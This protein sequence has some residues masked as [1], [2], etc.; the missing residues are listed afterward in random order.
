MSIKRTVKVKDQL[1][2]HWQKHADES[3]GKI[4]N[5]NVHRVG[6]LGTLFGT[7]ALGATVIGYFP[8][9]EL[10]QYVGA[11]LITANTG[12]AVTANYYFNK[13][14]TFY[15]KIKDYA[16][17][18]RN[19]IFQN[20]DLSTKTF[21]DVQLAD[22][23]E[24][25]NPDLSKPSDKR[26]YHINQAGIANI[27]AAGLLAWHLNS[28]DDGNVPTVRKIEGI[29]ALVVEKNRLETNGGVVLV[30]KAQ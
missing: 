22:L 27:F 14:K 16:E 13:D 8:S 10:T 3:H 12:L 1:I 2:A 15:K 18:K 21:T 20:I 19:D 26:L 11:L 23:I 7:T 9:N 30:P 17:T 28:S 5:A 25:E 29:S 24:S 6:T 4:M